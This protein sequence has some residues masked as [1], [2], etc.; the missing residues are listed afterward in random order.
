MFREKLPV[1]VRNHIAEMTFEQASYK[2]IFEKADKIY[3]SNQGDQ[4][5][6]GTVA[7]VTPASTTSEPEVSA[8]SAKNKGKNKNQRN[9][10][11]QTNKNRGQN[12]NQQTASQNSQAGQT[13]KAGR[14]PTAKGE[15]L[16]KIHF[17]FGVNANFCVKPFQCPMK[18]TLA[19]PQWSVGKLDFHEDDSN[20]NITD[21]SKI[22]NLIKI[23]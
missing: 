6:S 12:A 22:Q 21:N 7:A 17:K 16:C 11:G 15:N 9:Q 19:A 3:I 1:V 8:I 2:K 23:M 4:G 13:Q 18:D 20:D 10:G 5:R 14:H